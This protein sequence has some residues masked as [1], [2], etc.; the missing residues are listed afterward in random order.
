M[1]DKR[2]Y[3]KKHSDADEELI[4]KLL[5]EVAVYARLAQHCAWEMQYRFNGLES[6]EVDCD[7]M[8]KLKEKIF[9]LAADMK[10]PL[11]K[12]YSDEINARSSQYRRTNYMLQDVYEDMR[13]LEE[14]DAIQRKKAKEIYDEK[15]L[16]FSYKDEIPVKAKRDCVGE[17]K[18]DGFTEMYGIKTEPKEETE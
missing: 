13:D 2:V 7:S 1:A 15:P 5:I 11:Q 10:I 4:S 6:L 8:K 16:D 14:I 18:L 3:V 12:K 9:N 17:G